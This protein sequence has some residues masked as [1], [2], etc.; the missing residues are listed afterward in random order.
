MTLHQAQARLTL[1]ALGVFTFASP[2]LLSAQENHS[3]RSPFEVLRDAYA[4]GDAGQASRSYD[5]DAFYA[6]VYP[7]SK[8]T[9]RSGRA[10]I[11]SGFRQT[12]EQFG[13][14]SP[15]GA[16]LNFRLIEDKT[17]YGDGTI[18]G[19]YR[20]RTGKGRKPQDNYGQFATRTRAGLFTEDI[21]G[22]AEL[23]DF[24]N[25]KGPLLFSDKEEELAREYYE[26]PVGRYRKS[27]AAVDGNGCGVTI[28]LSTRR[29]YLLDECTGDWRG[30]SRV[31]GRAWTAGNRVIDPAVNEEIIFDPANKTLTRTRRNASPEVFERVPDVE[32]ID[33]RFGPG[34]ALA[35]TL[36]RPENAGAAKPG[37]VL[38][39]GSG[40]QDRNGYASIIAFLAERFAAHGTVVLT[41]DKRG[42]GQ[43]TGAWQSAGF[44]KLAADAKEAMVF[45]RAR[46]EVDPENVGLAGSSQAGWVVA[47]AIDNGAN[48]AFT[49][50]IGAAGSAL[51]VEEQNL[52]NTGVRMNCAGIAE[53]EVAL[54]LAQQRAFFAAKR[55]RK[56]VGALAEISAVAAKHPAIADWLFPA[57]VGSGGPPQ[58]Y[59]VL[60]PD[61]D[62][63]PIWKRYPGRAYF[64][65]GTM[66]DSTPAKVAMERLKDINERTRTLLLDGSQHLGMEATGLCKAELEQVSRFHPDFL[67]TLDDWVKEIA[68]DNR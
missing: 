33:V 35:G 18:T 53:D 40:P 25:A 3:T 1:L 65:F 12:F 29:Y 55:D 52:Y 4:K 51:T 19:Y 59:E 28:T 48:P 44:D 62:P 43:S 22:A 23:S 63:L 10:E 47:T 50:L 67:R 6:E 31:S 68:R 26:K 14:K 11:E 54:A 2:A 57:T 7:G 8:P 9:V 46:S 42:V 56:N 58:W 16:D 17:K 36:Y 21:S 24:E 15:A 34:D 61:F 13:L 60:D 39:H 30:L 5:Q 20:L 37:I 49:L 64:L 41:Y 66:D 45:L 27:G 32:R 38:V